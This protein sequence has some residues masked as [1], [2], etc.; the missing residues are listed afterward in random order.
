MRTITTSFRSLLLAGACNVSSAAAQAVPLATVERN[1]SFV[2]VE[3]FAPNIVHVTIA[4]ERD[5]IDSAP[6]DGR[7]ARSN[8]AGW[9]HQANNG[10]DVFSSG[11]FSLTVDPQPWP[12]A[13]DQMTRYFLPSLPPVSMSISGGMS[14]VPLGFVLI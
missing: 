12:G 6:N 5:L 3:P 4:P 10:G 13:P 11:S 9:S 8:A 14:S 2:A 7:V 1:G